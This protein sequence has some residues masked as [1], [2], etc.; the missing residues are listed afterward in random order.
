MNRATKAQK[1]K[2]TQFCGVTGASSSAALGILSRA[3]WDVAAAIN[4]YYSSGGAGS[5]RG[6][7]KVNMSAV[8]SLFGKYKDPSS[9]SILVDGV[10]QLCADLGVE[11]EDVVMLVL[12]WHFGAAAMGEYSQ[13]EWEQGLASL[14]LDS[15]PA[16]RA[17]LPTLRAEMDD[18]VLFAKIYAYAYPFS[19]DK[20]QKCVQQD[21]A[22]AMWH[23]LLPK[24][25]W[26]YVEEWCDFLK[27]NH[28][29]AISKDTWMQLLEFIR[30]IKPDFSN[31]DE[32]GSWPYLLDEF[33]EEMRPKL[34]N[35]SA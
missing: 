14:G 6:K 21:S 1:E 20:G 18:P 13:Q 26:R 17:A 23:I 11:P 16:L 33:V 30:T 31:Y 7:S 3:Q 28:N 19:C 34:T 22:L 10:V 8:R 35:G 4:Q 2:V 25:R 24:K 29:M 12:S 9:D 15:L 27:R 32:G 5:V